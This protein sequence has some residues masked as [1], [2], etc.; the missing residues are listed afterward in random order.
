MDFQRGLNSWQAFPQGD[1]AFSIQFMTIPSV[2]NAAKKLEKD[3]YYEGDSGNIQRDLGALDSCDKDAIKTN[4]FYVGGNLKNY[5]SYWAYKTKE[6]KA[7]K[8]KVKSQTIG[9][10][11]SKY[12]DNLEKAKANA[13]KQ[14]ANETAESWNFGYHAKKSRCYKQTPIKDAQGNIIDWKWEEKSYKSGEPSGSGWRTYNPP[15]GWTFYYDEEYDEVKYDYGTWDKLSSVESKTIVREL[16]K[17]GQWSIG[18]IQNR[19]SDTKY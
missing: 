17:R 19:P 8:A 5:M 1:A 14:R 3:N 4:D 15:S 7:L 13:Y 18:A 9:K 2:V 11:I 12:N 16:K 10:D 6:Y